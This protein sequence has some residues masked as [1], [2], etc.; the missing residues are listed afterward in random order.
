MNCSEIREKLRSG[1]RDDDAV[2]RHVS[3]CAACASEAESERRLSELIRAVPRAEA[4]AGFESAVFRR[5]ESG[6][7]SSPN[8][9]LL[10]LRILVPAAAALVIAVLAIALSGV[11]SGDVGPERTLVPDQPPPLDNGGDRPS[12][13]SAPA[14]PA[15][16]NEQVAQAPEV[17]GNVPGNTRT[18]AANPSGEEKRAGGTS[19]DLAARPVETIDPPWVDRNPSRLP[20]PMGGP[21]SVSPRDVLS[22]FGIAAVRETIGWRV[23]D[24]RR[25]SISEGA[26][27]KNGD[28]LVELDGTPLGDAPLKGRSVKGKKL[29]LVRDGQRLTVSLTP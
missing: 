1:D 10:K 4:P 20:D 6:R 14:E 27:V 26:G 12:G 25:N 2:R 19:T 18:P 13:Q 28:L 21:L 16:A 17:T 23:T 8:V 11:F 15:E 3:T 22:M 5:I 9:S 29:T 24:V 7:R